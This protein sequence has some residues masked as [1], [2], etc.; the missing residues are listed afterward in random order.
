MA[1]TVEP[2]RY[3]TA[4]MA[5]VRE[6]R[7]AGWEIRAIQR[8]IR[9]EGHPNVPGRETILRWTNEHYANS[10][11]RKQRRHYASVNAA[12][13]TFRLSSEQPEY[14]DAF[15]RRLREEGVPVSSIAKVMRVVFRSPPCEETLRTRFMDGGRATGMADPATQQEMT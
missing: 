4:L 11:R 10:K 15:A 7:R 1:A 14:K 13:A 5:Y 12:N 8:V 2:P 3:S 9:D 6:L